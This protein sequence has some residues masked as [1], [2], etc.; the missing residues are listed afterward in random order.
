LAS[1]QIRHRKWPG[2]GETGIFAEDPDMGF[3][4]I[5]GEFYDDRFPHHGFLIP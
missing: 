3:G 4:I 5:K 1:K 2:L